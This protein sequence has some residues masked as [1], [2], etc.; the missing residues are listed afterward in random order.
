LGTPTTITF[1]PGGQ[2]SASH[3]D[4]RSRVSGLIEPTFCTLSSR[5]G[6]SVPM[7]SA[8][9]RA[10]HRELRPVRCRQAAVSR[11]AKY[12]AMTATMGSTS[13]M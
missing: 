11:T 2:F 5:G 10:M 8:T 3:A 4:A 13:T 7:I 9:G 12:A 6:V 1:A